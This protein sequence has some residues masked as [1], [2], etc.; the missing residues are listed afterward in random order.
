M[1]RKYYSHRLTNLK[2]DVY[3]LYEK[4]KNLY[5]YFCDK[6]YF[7]GIEGIRHAYCPDRIKHKAAA[8]LSFQPFPIDKWN[9]KDITE[10]KIF[11]TLEFLY[12]LTTKPTSFIMREWGY[13][14]YT[15]YDQE[16]G[17][18]EFIKQANIFLNTYEAGYEMNNSGEIVKL[19]GEGIEYIINAEIIPYD[20]EHVDSKI[21]NA[22]KKWKSRK[23]TTEE[24]KEVI[25]DL[26]DVLEWVR[27]KFKNIILNQDDNAIFNILNNFHIRHNNQKQK[28]NYDKEI[29]FSWMFHF[30]LATY[31]AVIRFILKKEKLKQV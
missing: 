1:S 13:K 26:A 28:T 16:T 11:D 2:I 20:E 12:D 7:E 19:G 17:K 27:P 21:R 15:K 5:L 18:K 22:I 10:E 6:D 8:C 14:E 30:Y 23:I 9:T 4:V 25:R 3:Q 24:K 29:W 31:H